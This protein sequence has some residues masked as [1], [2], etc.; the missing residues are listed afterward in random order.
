MTLS[1]ETINYMLRTSISADID[2]IEFT[3][4]FDENHTVD[5]TVRIIFEDEYID[6]YRLT[7]LIEKNILSGKRCLTAY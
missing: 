4:T 6:I 3:T 5:E 2:S 1:H 7:S